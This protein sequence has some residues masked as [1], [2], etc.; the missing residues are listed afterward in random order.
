[1]NAIDGP[2]L[3]LIIEDEQIF[4]V[5]FNL[6]DI[7]FFPSLTAVHLEGGWKDHENLG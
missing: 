5:S 3:P 4:F 1:M 2:R 7:Y 6:F